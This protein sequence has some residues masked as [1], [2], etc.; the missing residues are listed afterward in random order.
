MTGVL[1]P[2]PVRVTLNHSS[3]HKQHRCSEAGGWRREGMEKEDSG[4][5]RREWSQDDVT[6]KG[7]R[8]TSASL[9]RSWPGWQDRP[10][11][12]VLSQS[13]T[14]HT[15]TRATLQATCTEITRQFWGWSVFVL[16][17]AEIICQAL[18]GIVAWMSEGDNVLFARPAVVLRVANVTYT[19]FTYLLSL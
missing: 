12:C 16:H 19:Q 6:R 17:F 1:S 4:K 14:T 10:S 5:K 7:G 11:L 8:V 9:K 18:R 3:H 2:S 15:V 13:A